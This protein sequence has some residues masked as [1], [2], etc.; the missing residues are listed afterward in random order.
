MSAR[1]N[2]EGRLPALFARGGFEAVSEGEAIATIWG[3]LAL[4]SARRPG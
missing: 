4:Y 1:D 3:T 2:V